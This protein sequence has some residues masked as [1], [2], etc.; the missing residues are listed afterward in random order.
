M[1]VGGQKRA[2]EFLELELQMIASHLVGGWWEP[3]QSVVE[4]P[5]LLM[6]E[7]PLRP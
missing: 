7:P 6:V 2:S 3:K 4:H 1:P 5:V